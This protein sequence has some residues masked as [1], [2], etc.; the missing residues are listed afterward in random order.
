ME[1]EEPLTPSITRDILP[2]ILSVV[3]LLMSDTVI[4]ESLDRADRRVTAEYS[5][6]LISSQQAVSTG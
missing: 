2:V 6:A 5:S 3:L 4:S 1:I